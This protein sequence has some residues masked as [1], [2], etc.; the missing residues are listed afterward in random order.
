ML[1]MLLEE[2]GLLFVELFVEVISQVV[3]VVGWDD[4]LFMLI[5]IWVEIFGEMVV[6]VVIDRFCLVV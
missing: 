3:I 6:L 2:I 1:L 5:G 4:M